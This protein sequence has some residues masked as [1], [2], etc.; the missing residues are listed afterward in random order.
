MKNSGAVNLLDNVN[1]TN[2]QIFIEI[3]KKIAAQGA[4]SEEKIFETSCE[5]FQEQRDTKQNNDESNP[6]SA[7]GLVSNFSEAQKV[8]VS[9]LFKN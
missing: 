8:K 6:P 2:C 9:D 1:Q 5:M 3:Y 4:L 7:P